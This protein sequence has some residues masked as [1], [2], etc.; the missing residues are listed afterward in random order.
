VEREYGSTKPNAAPLRAH[1]GAQVG[2]PPPLRGL[3]PPRPPTSV[4][5][6]SG[7]DPLQPSRA[8]SAS[9]SCACTVKSSWGRAARGGTERAAV[10][11]SAARPM[12]G[13]PLPK[14]RWRSGR[15]ARACGAPSQTKPAPAPPAH[16]PGVVR[17]RHFDLK[18]PPGP[19]AARPARRRAAAA[20]ADAR[21]ARAAAAA[22][23]TTAAAAAAAAALP[24]RAAGP[25]GRRGRSTRLGSAAAAAG[26]AAPLLRR[27]LGGTRAGRGGARGSGAAAAGARRRRGGPLAAGMASGKR[28]RPARGEHGACRAGWAAGL[29]SS[30]GQ[31]G[32]S[33]WPPGR[34]ERE[35]ML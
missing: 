20:A 10:G 23:T 19:V 9:S 31:G 5:A 33:L 35:M 6:P 16:L 15:Q 18:H 1:T 11:A 21:T 22:A 8:S 30:G 29:G 13:L 12:P 3:A 27:A 2:R 26:A 14:R 7:S 17:R 34:L 25:G 28:V 32:G 24:P 4:T